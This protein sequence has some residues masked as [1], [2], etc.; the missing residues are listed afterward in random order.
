[1]EDVKNPKDKDYLRSIHLGKAIF[2]DSDFDNT[3]RAFDEI[4][5]D[6][7]D[8]ANKNKKSVIARVCFG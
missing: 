7:R 8:L 2:E 4:V 1:M 5:E 3:S 6:E